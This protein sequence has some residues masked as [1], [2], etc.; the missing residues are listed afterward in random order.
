MEESKG[1]IMGIEELSFD[2]LAELDRH[3]E[4]KNFV[5]AKY[6]DSELTEVIRDTNT[7]KYYLVSEQ[8]GNED[9]LWIE[10][11]PTEITKIVYLPK[12]LC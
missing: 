3:G 11:F 8:E 4:Y 12:E 10:V 5:V 1:K 9:L 6:D 7:D 2:I